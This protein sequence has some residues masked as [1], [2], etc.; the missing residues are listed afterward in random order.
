VTQAQL[1]HFARDKG[2]TQIHVF[3]K[4]TGA[5]FTSSILNAGSENDFNTIVEVDE[6]LN[7]EAMFDE[8]DAAGAAI[9]AQIVERRSLCWMR[10]AQV[11]AL[12]DLG[13]VQ[14]LRTKLAREM[15][16][17]L[18]EEMREI[19]GSFGAN[20]TDPQFAP[21]TET[22]AKRGTIEAFLKRA[23][24]RDSFLRLMPGLVEP[25]GRDLAV[26][27][28]ALKAGRQYFAKHHQGFLIDALG[29]GVEAGVGM[30]N[31]DIFRL[32]T[33]DHVAEDPAAGRTIRIHAAATIIAAATGRD[34]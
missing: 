7:F 19:L 22:D 10:E 18:A 31:A 5:N 4:N 13:A 1:R 26:Q 24:H 27:D 30:G 28:A 8:V 12:A 11:T 23:G 33:I 34:A 15:P 14:L 21:P 32:G 9:V 6:R 17:V 25:A 3:D 20:L 29:D 2:G 16:G